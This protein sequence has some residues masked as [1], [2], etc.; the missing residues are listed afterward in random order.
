M[1]GLT[2]QQ[3]DDKRKELHLSALTA[4]KSMGIPYDGS[5]FF[6][7]AWERFLVAFV[8]MQHDER[9]SC[10]WEEFKSEVRRG[11][12]YCRAK[13]DSGEE[14]KY[15]RLGN[16]IHDPGILMDYASARRKELQNIVSRRKAS[17][18]L[19]A[20]H[21]LAKMTAE[22]HFEQMLPIARKS[23]ASI[24]EA[25]KHTQP[26]PEGHII[27]APAKIRP[28]KSLNSLITSVSRKYPKHPK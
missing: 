18:K 11:V 26:E 14:K 8:G 24:R 12:A 20:E 2:R 10:T 4:W 9:S 15:N 7:Q 1:E 27:Y 28:D 21:P 23:F 13:V 17:R 6:S 19:L 16:V 25:A 22:E 5:N 3:R